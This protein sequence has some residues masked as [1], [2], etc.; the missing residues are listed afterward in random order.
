MGRMNAEGMVRECGHMP[1][2]LALGWHL[3]SN[4]FPPVPLAWVASCEDVI[5]RLSA[6]QDPEEVID[7]PVREGET[8]TLR[9]VARGLHLDP[10]ITREEV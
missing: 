7:N 9:E 2:E 5:D 1:R 10:W 6:G 8:V 4:H 3:Q